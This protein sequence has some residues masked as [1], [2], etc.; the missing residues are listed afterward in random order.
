MV[1]LPRGAEVSRLHVCRR[2]A[3]IDES[4]RDGL[5]SFDEATFDETT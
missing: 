3:A 2:C 4:R 1:I 5:P